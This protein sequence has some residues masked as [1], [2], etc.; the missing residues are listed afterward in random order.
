MLAVEVLPEI[1]KVD[2][3]ALKVER[4][5]VEI[6]KKEVDG[7]L[8]ELVEQ[9]RPTKPIAKPRGVKEGDNGG[10]GFHRAY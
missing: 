2:V 4:F 7:A 1:A 5:N 6:S 10:D 3:K 8:Q 9:N